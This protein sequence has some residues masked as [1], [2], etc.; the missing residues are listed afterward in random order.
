VGQQWTLTRGA[1]MALA[2]A[3]YGTHVQGLFAQERMA[4]FRTSIDLV[5]LSVTVNNATQHYVGDLQQDD[6]VVL[7]N[8]VAQRLTFFAKTNVPLAL[9]LLVDSSASMEQALP[10]AQDAAIGFVRTLDP[11]DT[12]TIVDFDSRVETAQSFTSDVRAL[13]EAVRRTQAGGATALYN[14][15]YIALKE[16]RKQGAGDDNQGRRRAII[17]LSD[18]DD[19]SSLVSFEELLDA[20]TESDTLIYTI[21]LGIGQPVGMRVDSGQGQFVL[22]RLAQQTGGRA[23]FPKEPRDLAGVYAEIRQELSRQYSLAYESNSARRNG[24][25]RRI[26]V[27]VNRP[28]VIV[29][30]KL[31]YFAPNK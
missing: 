7:E 1:A 29:R 30:N 24:E 12:A 13:E 5:S 21:G 16:M 4:P 17:V 20:V 15:V 11:R 3:T 9:A 18:G 2:L 6:F 23:F 28:D 22:K 26:T 19:T 27:R 14:A 10:I 8:G 25:W 31:G